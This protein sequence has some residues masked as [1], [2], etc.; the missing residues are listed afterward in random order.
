MMVVT[1]GK[2]VTVTDCEAQR[3]K[4]VSKDTRDTRMKQHVNG[5]DGVKIKLSIYEEK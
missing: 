3:Q 2:T 4:M 5:K 1:C